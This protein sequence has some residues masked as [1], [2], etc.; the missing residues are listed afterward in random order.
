MSEEELNK[1]LL[2]IL[3]AHRRSYYGMQRVLTRC[4]VCERPLEEERFLDTEF[5][6]LVVENEPILNAIKA[7]FAK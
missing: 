3:F 6:Q 4:E 7:V 5:E 2:L 1:E